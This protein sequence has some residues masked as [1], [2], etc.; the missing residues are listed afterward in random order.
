MTNKV[1]ELK[2]YLIVAVLM[3]VGL[4]WFIV[5]ERKSDAAAPCGHDY[6]SQYGPQDCQDY[7]QQQG[8]QDDFKDCDFKPSC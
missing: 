5:D 3:I 6:I 7:R 1:E 4:V 2:V 8:Q